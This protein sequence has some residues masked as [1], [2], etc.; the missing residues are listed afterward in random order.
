MICVCPKIPLLCLSHILTVHS[1]THSTENYIECLLYERD[2]YILGE[3]NR[4]DSCSY[5]IDSV[6]VTDIKHI[7]VCDKCLEKVKQ[8]MIIKSN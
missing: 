6:G 7:H 1:F 4:Q 8:G 5:R 2:C 3:E